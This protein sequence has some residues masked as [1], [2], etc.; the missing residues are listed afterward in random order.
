MLLLLMD[1]GLGIVATQEEKYDFVIK[2]AKGEYRFNEIIKWIKKF[3]D[4][5]NSL[6]G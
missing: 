2:V 6:T 3:T 4:N 5:S 1:N